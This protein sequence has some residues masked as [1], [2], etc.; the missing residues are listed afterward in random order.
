MFDFVALSC[1]GV[2]VAYVRASA[3][4]TPFLK[5]L[6]RL[7]WIPFVLL[8]YGLLVFGVFMIESAARHVAVSPEVLAQYGDAGKY[9][10]EMHKK[11]IAVGSVVFFGTALVDYRWIRWF[12]LPFYVVSLVL[13]AQAMRQDDA[14]HRLAIGGF[15]FQP[16]QLGVAAGILVISWLL[17]DLPKLHRWL[18][19]PFVRIGIIGVVAAVPFFMVMKMGDMGSA[20]VWIPVVVVALLVG[21]VPFRHISFMALIGVGCC[22]CCISS[23]CRWYRSVVRS[24]STP[25]CG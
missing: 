13:M 9:F 7:N 14:V 25:G 23:R 19:A 5:K 11:W 8:I 17:Q 12:G 3:A 22:R 18:G 1:H 24:G 15:S 4:M 2:R 16:A 21:G 20:L 10:A 6:L